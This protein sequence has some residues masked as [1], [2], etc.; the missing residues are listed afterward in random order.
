MR[1]R[2]RERQQHGKIRKIARLYGPSLVAYN[3]LAREAER[4][5]YNGSIEAS[6]ASDVGS[7]PIARSINKA[8]Q[9]FSSLARPYFGAQLLHNSFRGPPGRMGI[10]TL[11]QQSRLDACPVT[12]DVKELS[13]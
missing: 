7:I 5:S 10:L 9:D 8:L 3:L 1:C 6:Q 2:S 13:R 4:A 11:F 12:L